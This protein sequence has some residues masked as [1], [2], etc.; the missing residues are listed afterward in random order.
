MYDLCLFDLD[1]TLSDPKV[2]ITKGHQFALAAFGIHEEL[3]NLTKCIGPPLRENFSKLFGLSESDTEKAVAEYRKYYGTIG[4]FENTVYPEIPELL[5]TLKACG[6]ILAVAT[7]KVIEYSARSL[8]HFGLEKYF[9]F[10]SG[11][12]MDGSLTKNGKQE[13]IRIALEKLEMLLSIACIK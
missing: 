9:A 5:E 7:N 3:E 13:I 4:L 12:K 2:G 11:D 1:G 6:K 10:V 8:K